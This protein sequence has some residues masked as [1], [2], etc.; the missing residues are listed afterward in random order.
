[1]ASIFDKI[2]K[3]ITGSADP[4]LNSQPTAVDKAIS[5]TATKRTEQRNA[6][7]NKAGITA[8]S[9]SFWKRDDKARERYKT[10][11]P[12]AEEELRRKYPN[13]TEDQLNQGLDNRR[14]RD[15]MKRS[16]NPKVKEL[17]NS[18]FDKDGNFTDYGKQNWQNVDD[19]MA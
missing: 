19:M 7:R 17:Y 2:L 6:A 18:M 1:M 10:A 11:N 4:M 8:D 5:R 15:I 16:T 9:S 13:I 12:L 14:K 3:V